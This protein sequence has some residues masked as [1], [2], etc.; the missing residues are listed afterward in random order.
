MENVAQYTV[1]Q[2]KRL[3]IPYYCSVYMQVEIKSI[4]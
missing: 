1:L 3:N 4:K 2:Q